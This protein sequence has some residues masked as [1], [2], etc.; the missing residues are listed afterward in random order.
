MSKQLISNFNIS[1]SSLDM[2]E[3]CPRRWAHTYIYKTPA[4]K[5]EQRPLKIGITFHKLME[6]FYSKYKTIQWKKNWLVENWEDYYFSEMNSIG[7][8]D[9]D[10][11]D[12][13]KAINN[14]YN[15]LEKQQWFYPAMNITGKSGVEYYFKFPFEGND[16]Y[17]VNISGKIDLLLNRDNEICVIDWKTGK[18]K[19]WQ[20]ETL[21]DSV[22]LILYSAALHKLIGIEEE[23]LFLVYAYVDNIKQFVVNTE[24][25]EYVKQKVNDLLA[26][27][28]T[29][30]YTTKRGF[31]CQNCEF[32]AHC[33]HNI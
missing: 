32:Q 17:R 16:K 6:D 8:I 2:F 3:N 30:G 20:A 18:S 13:Y 7:I 1:A 29:G 25:F 9:Q 26:V 14:V 12:G 21:F 28:E 5:I 4:K 24:H 10:I 22:Q 23:Q 15:I 11:A 27:Y 31:F 19:N 33:K